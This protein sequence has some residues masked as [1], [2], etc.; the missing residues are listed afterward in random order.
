MSTYRKPHLEQCAACRAEAARLAA[1]LSELQNTAMP[2]PSPLFWSHLSTRVRDAVAADSTPTRWSAAWMRWP[3]LA[4]LAAMALLVMTLATI[5]ARPPVPVL[6]AAIVATTASS[7][8]DPVGEPEWAALMEML[9]PLDLD[10]AHDAGIVSVGDAERV[11]LQ[12]SASEQR[13]LVRLL[14]EE[15]EKVGS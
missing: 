5:V 7:E 8:A 14:E 13:E 10:A 1:L 3:V 2:E 11:A 4:P 9:G 15:M 6:P 12:L